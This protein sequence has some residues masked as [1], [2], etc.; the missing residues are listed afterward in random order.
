MG[1]S[2]WMFVASPAPGVLGSKL[3]VSR[4]FVF[5]GFVFSLLW[6]ASQPN[7]GL[8]A[9]RPLLYMMVP[10]EG[11]IGQAFFVKERRQPGMSLV[12]ARATPPRG[13]RLPGRGQ[14]PG[15]L[16]AGGGFVGV[17]DEVTPRGSGGIGWLAFVPGSS[18]TG[19]PPTEA[20]PRPAGSWNHSSA[21]ALSASSAACM[22]SC[23]AGAATKM[24]SEPV[25]S[26]V[27][28]GLPNQKADARLGV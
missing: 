3:T 8:Q 6:P 15:F 25:V 5:M 28:L 18:Q 9:Y 11:S 17:V 1:L 14:S 16:V 7:V 2:R 10:G 4:C 27:E 13:R 26:G 21:G 12:P 24:P 22:N 19:A 23:H 20:W